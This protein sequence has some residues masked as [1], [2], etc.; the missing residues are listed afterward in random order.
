MVT[1]LPPGLEAPPPPPPEPPRRRSP[2]WP[3]VLFLLTFFSALYSQTPALLNEPWWSYATLPFHA[4]LRLLAGLPFAATL[5]AILLAHE[6]GHYLTA[7][8]YGVDQ[9]LPLFIPAPTFFGTLGAVIF[10]RSQPPTRRVLLHIAVMG[11]YAGMFLAIPA[12]AWGLAH[13]MPI[14]AEAALQGGMEFGD[15][16]LFAILEAL[17]SPNGTDVVLHPV[18]MAGWVGLFIT[19]LNLIPAAQLDGGHVSYA[20]FGKTHEKI[21]LAVVVALLC[22]GLHSACGADDA[23]DGGGGMWILW[24]LLLFVIGIRHPPVEDESQPLRLGDKFNGAVALL[25]F[26]LTFIP[27]PVRLLHPDEL[28]QEDPGVENG[29]Y[30]LDEPRLAPPR[31]GLPNGEGLEEEGPAEGPDHEL[32]PEDDKTEDGKPA[33]EFTL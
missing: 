21:S 30:E 26:L 4:P 32:A 33:E 23:A 10:M 7:R 19:S 9:S 31:P 16:I 17:F 1:H 28:P 5:M 20:L 11:P 2:L 8:A 27:I 14:P 24:G 29:P 25:V 12:A 3:I 6:M 22:F 13:S 18:A 15:S